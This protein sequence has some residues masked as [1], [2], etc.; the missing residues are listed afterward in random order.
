MALL[1]AA[2]IGIL[3]GLHMRSVVGIGVCSADQLVS[4]HHQGCVYNIIKKSIL[5]CHRERNDFFFRSF[6]RI[7]LYTAG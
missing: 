6:R 4:F 2:R 3:H 1:G 5:H 7:L